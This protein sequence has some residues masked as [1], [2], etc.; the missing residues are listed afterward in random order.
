MPESPFL[1]ILAENLAASVSGRRIESIDIRQPALLMTASPPPESFVGEFLSLPVRRGKYLILET[2]SRRAIVLHLMRLGRLSIVP[3]PASA[4]KPAKNVSARIRFDDDSEL[5]LVE[6][7]T[8]KRARLWLAEDPDD[9]AE[10][11]TIGPDPARG[12]MDDA[13]F[14]TAL[15]A[16]SRQIKGFLTDQRA[17]S[18]IGNGLSD[19]ILYEARLSPLQL[20]RNVSD[21][22]AARLYRAT[23]D[24]LERQTSALRASAAGA[25]PQREPSEHYTVHDHAGETCGRCGSTIARISY[26]DRETYY[27]PG[28]QT[29]GAPLKDRRLSKLLK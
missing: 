17:I 6:H 23:L 2:E 24:V 29:G 8:E 9:V 27:C 13:A 10:L 4:R 7:G 1:E 20:T 11:R 19:E 18:G 15:R 21:E 3:A 28:C 16:E 14:R 26:A 25:L 12:E 5:R 22:E